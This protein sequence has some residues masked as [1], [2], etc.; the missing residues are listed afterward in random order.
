MKTFILVLLGWCLSLA[1]L[2]Q[3]RLPPSGPNI[4]AGR[5]VVVS[6]LENGGQFPASAA[7]DGNYGTRWSSARSDAQW[8]YVDLG[9][10]HKITRLE[11]NWQTAYGK[12]YDI[13]VSS[14]LGATK[15]WTT[16][17]QVRGNRNLL[18]NELELTGS[19]QFVR[20]NCLA[21]GTGYG[22]SLYELV[23]YD[24]NTPPTVILT[25]PADH[26]SY[27]AAHITLAANA[28]DA[29]GTVAQVAFYSGSTL[30]GIDRTSPYTY[31][32]YNAPVGTPT[33]YAV[34]TDGGGVSTTSYGRFIYVDGPPPIT[35]TSPAE[36]ATY[37]A[38]RAITLTA[39]IADGGQTGVYFYS[40]ST[41]LGAGEVVAFGA[42]PL[43]YSYTWANVPAGTYAI[44]A[45]GDRNG[46][47]ATTPACTITVKAATSPSIA[48]T[49]SARGVVANTSALSAYPNP[50]MATLTLAG[51]AAGPATVGIYDAKGALVQAVQLAAPGGQA[52]LDVSALP[53]GLYLLRVTSQA[54]SQTRRFAKE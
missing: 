35:L 33:I 18:D 2:S 21:R 7:T 32:W 54:G 23:V 4:A 5:P 10:V 38:G 3:Q 11:I 39:S 24:T 20:L 28:A 31:E 27:A 12:D 13:Q 43:V 42:T 6:S 25:Q 45:E 29:D 50:A 52:A 17:R 37:T 47:S 26:S 15:S 40:G 44:T 19:G 16:I 46:Q 48:T 14:D 36:G 22:Y 41:Y 53:T 9:A 49:T 51:L 8:I 30:L 34:A 1:A